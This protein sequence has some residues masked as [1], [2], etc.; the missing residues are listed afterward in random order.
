MATGT[1]FLKQQAQMIQNTKLWQK[2]GKGVKDTLN[3]W[4]GPMGLAITASIKFLVG[5]KAVLVASQLVGRS[6]EAWS[7]VQY[8]TPSFTKLLGGLSQAKSRLNDL[9]R[10][11]A[12]GPFKF[13][14]LVAAN[15][16]M[17]TLTRGAYS[18]KKA[19]LDVADAAAAAGIAPEAAAEAIGGAMQAISR[20]EG[21]D[22]AIDSLGQ[23][24]IVSTVAADSLRNLARSGASEEQMLRSLEGALGR[25]KG[26]AAALG[27]TLQG[28]SEQMATA[29]E[30]NLAGIG[31]MFAEGQAAGMQAGLVLI[32]QF[33]PVLIDFLKPVAAVFNSWN[34]LLLLMAN[35][36]AWE[37]VKGAVKAVA[38]LLTSL[39]AAFAIK[40][41]AIFARDVLGLLGILKN[42]AGPAAKAAGGFRLVGLAAL[43]LGKM[44][45]AALG[46]VGML[47]V[48]L[49]ALAEIMGVFENHG[50]G[51]I[52]DVIAKNAA[53]IKASNDEVRNMLAAAASGGIGEKA[54]AMSKAGTALQEATAARVAAEN[55]RPGGGGLLK[56]MLSGAAAGGMLTKNW[57]GMVAGAVAGVGMSLNEKFNQS[58]KDI[59]E[60]RANERTAGR[61]LDDAY[62][63]A[64]LTPAQ[65]MNDPDYARAKAEGE[66]KME[67]I[68]AKISEVM[69]M[70][71]G[72]GREEEIARLNKQFAQVANG[73]QP[74]ALA[75][76]F[77]QRMAATATQATVMRSIGEATGDRSKTIEADRIEAGMREEA[78]KKELQAMGIDEQKAGKMAKADGLASL[79]ETLRSNG[80]VFASGRASVGGAAGEAAGG[81]PP[82]FR[83]V[84]EEIKKI[85]Q[86]LQGGNEGS[87]Q[88]RVRTVMDS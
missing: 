42:I 31:N 86:D 25:N 45:K 22:G 1:D 76:A 74:E 55:K 24:G 35:A 81:I 15:R 62:S 83:A 5:I 10:M 27:G 70:A 63:Q 78:R 71:P 21:V 8:Y 36:A 6:L 64:A 79:A 40:G 59:A 2:H 53:D 49:G 66:A 13:E 9:V 44:I 57:L 37:Y 19:M 26:A 52:G 84:I 54:D 32:R 65:Y 34:K 51:G 33:G 12:S 23:M 18:G 60:A 30:A 3:E 17:E 43:G 58:P 75:K 46:P 72:K 61:N 28:L 47:A 16:R 48:A 87:Q 67:A 11:S 88:E 80:Q 20:H 7:R 29:S 77:N 85:Q 41:V 4:I 82:E 39:A 68:S 50:S 38:A 73:V 56:N 69:Q 14:S